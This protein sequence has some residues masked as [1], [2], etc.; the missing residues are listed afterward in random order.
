MSIKQN[1]LMAIMINV[2]QQNQK[3]IEK[4]EKRISVLESN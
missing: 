3:K 4:L 1:Q 2:I